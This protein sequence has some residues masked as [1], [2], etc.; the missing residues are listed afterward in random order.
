MDVEFRT[1]MNA[2]KK[3][4]SQKVTEYRDE[5]KQL[6]QNFDNTKHQAEAEA[7]KTG[8]AARNR[9]VTA[10]QRLDDSTMRLEQ[11]R[12]L[13]GQ[14]EQVG[15]TIITDLESQKETLQDASKK[16]QETK[17][18][19][20][21]ARGVLKDMTRRALMHKLACLLVIITLLGL[22]GVTAYYGILKKSDK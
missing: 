14:T 3:N 8:P 9:L 16:V 20:V 4:A 12:M 22:I 11:S 10:N 6:R 15:N 1:M 18:F 21:D 13:I 2:D 5:F 19:T 7:L 17:Q